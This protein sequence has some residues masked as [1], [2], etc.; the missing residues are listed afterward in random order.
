MEGLALSLPFSL[1]RGAWEQRWVN[2]KRLHSGKCGSSCTAPA[3]VSLSGV[4]FF[5]EL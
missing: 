3:S 4:G 5:G 2:S 1:L